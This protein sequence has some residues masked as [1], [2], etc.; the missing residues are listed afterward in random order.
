[1]EGAFE[2]ENFTRGEGLGLTFTGGEDEE[3][4]CMDLEGG[5]RGVKEG[6]KGVVEATLVDEGSEDDELEDGFTK[7]GL[8]EEP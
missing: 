5:G 4:A 2:E 6:S 3:L 8:V 7:E 1:M